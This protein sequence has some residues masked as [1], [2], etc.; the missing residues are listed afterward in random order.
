MANAGLALVWKQVKTG[1]EAQALELF[2][3]TMKYYTQLRER[4]EIQ[5]FEP[6][7]FQAHGGE[8]NG[9]VHVRGTETQIDTLRRADKF[10]SM[11]LQCI[12]C[13]DGFGVVDAITGDQLNQ[14]MAEWGQLIGK[15]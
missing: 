10:R 15:G 14:M 7:L 12:Y 1:R 2:G 8:L 3:S 4:G 9:F 6:V 11:T 5:S 13:L